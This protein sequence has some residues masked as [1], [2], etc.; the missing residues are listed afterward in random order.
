[1]T[2]VENEVKSFNGIKVPFTGKC[3]ANINY[4]GMS[5]QVQ[6]HVSPILKDDVLIGRDLIRMFKIELHEINIENE[7]LE[8]NLSSY[9]KE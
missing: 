3:L 5:K 7:E 1:M 4:K 9:K 8:S 6:I 2:K